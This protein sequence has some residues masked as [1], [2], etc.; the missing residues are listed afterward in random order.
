MFYAVFPQKFI[1]TEYASHIKKEMFKREAMFF[2]AT[3]ILIENDNRRRKFVEDCDSKISSLHQELKKLRKEK[4]DGI[5]ALDHEYGDDEEMFNPA[6]KKAKRV[7]TFV[8]CC[9]VK[10]CRGFL[11][12]EEYR[13]GLC[14][15][16][17]CSKCHE[18]K[19]VDHVCNTDTIESVKAILSTTRGCPNCQTRIFKIEGCDQMYCTICKIAFSWRTGEIDNGKKH[20]PHFYE[21]LRNNGIEVPRDPNDVQCGGL[22]SVAYFRNFT[23]KVDVTFN[24]IRFTRFD[25]YIMEVHRYLVHLQTTEIDPLPTRVDNVSNIDIRKKYLCNEITTEQFE[26]LLYKR[27]TVREK[28]LEMRE[29]LETYYNIVQELF[30]SF[31]RIIQ[32]K[33]S[34]DLSDTDEQRKAKVDAYKDKI[35]RFMSYFMVSEQKIR[36]HIIETYKKM[37]LMYKSTYKCPLEKLS[38]K[39]EKVSVGHAQSYTPDAYQLL[40]QQ[41]AVL[42]QQQLA[43]ARAQQAAATQQQP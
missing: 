27:E 24:G 40:M 19:S 21:D 4:Q 43:A 30:T 3:Q 12:A 37:N 7:V 25:Q 34:N 20:N 13:C 32:A 26:D 18:L 35:L 8:G 1:K 17:A 5:V 10:D 23:V 9:P 11:S 39:E 41:Q 6:S 15:A 16:E 36:D 29:Y 28:R 31:V 42:A 22:P 38:R 33:P 2:P 14:K